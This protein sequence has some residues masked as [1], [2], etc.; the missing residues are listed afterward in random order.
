M[1]SAIAI[2]R[3]RLL[4]RDGVLPSTHTPRCAGR[5]SFLINYALMLLLKSYCLFDGSLSLIC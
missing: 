5:V 4:D 2:S 3:A 1:S